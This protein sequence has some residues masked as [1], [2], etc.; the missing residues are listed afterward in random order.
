MHPLVEL[1]KKAVEEFVRNGARIEPPAGTEG[2]MAR[3][4]G[5]FVSLKK[6]GR[7]RGCIGTIEPTAENVAAEVIRN[8]VHSATEDRRF[9]PVLEEELGELEYSVD[10]L[11]EPEDIGG[12]EE[13]DASKY[14]VIVAK[15]YRRGL[16]LPDLEGVDSV[17]EQLR[18]ACQKAGIEPGEEGIKMQRFEVKRYR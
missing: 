8:A 1:A 9:Q 10:V 7:L 3:K 17:Q 11:T 12:P 16:L 2:L 15:G 13:L 18:I 5:A 6:G 14:G 4:A